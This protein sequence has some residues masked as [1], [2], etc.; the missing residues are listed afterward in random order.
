MFYPPK[1]ADLPFF[2]PI[3]LIME[4]VSRGLSVMS[5]LLTALPVL[6]RTLCR[7]YSS[8]LM[9]TGIGIVLTGSPHLFKRRLA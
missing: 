8:D 4:L 3:L 7:Y 2:R 6:I 1:L 9:I 5:P